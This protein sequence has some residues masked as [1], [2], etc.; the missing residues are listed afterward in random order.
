VNRSDKKTYIAIA[1][2]AGFTSLAQMPSALANG[3]SVIPGVGYYSFDSEYN[4]DDATAPAIGLQYLFGKNIAIEANYSQ[5]E[6]DIENTSN[7]FDWTHTRLDAFYNFTGIN[8][9]MI[10][11]IVAGAGEAVSE[12]N[13]GDI[14]ETLVNAG[15]GIKFL[16]D[17]GFSIIA[18]LRAVNSIDQEYTSGLASLAFSYTMDLTGGSRSSEGDIDL[19]QQETPEEPPAIE[20]ADQDGIADAN[21]ECLNTPVGVAIDE[22]GCGLDGDNDG[23]ADYRDECAQTPAD[24]AVDS[25]GCPSDLDGDGIADYADKCPTSAAN[26]L[27]DDTGCELQVSENISFQLNSSVLPAESLRKIEEL[28]TFLK[29][30]EQTIAIIEGHS[31]AS[32]EAAYNEHL[33]GLRAAQ[34]K[35]ILINQFNISPERLKTESYGETRPIASNDTLEGRQENRRVTT[36]I[37]VE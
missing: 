36:K 14:D 24:V 34:V 29:R 17:R 23:I 9:K 19:V 20:D 25:L 4:L 21:D 7:D 1:M 27:I 35:E 11:Y 2:A 10:P 30:Y 37:V 32:G 22:T 3:I 33:S 15:A 18:D 12:L 8:D 31:D 13:G 26:T 6:V 5:S 28:A 16:L